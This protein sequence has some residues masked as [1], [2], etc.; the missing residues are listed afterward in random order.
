MRGY[1]VE[2]RTR[3][4]VKGYVIIRKEIKKDLL[5][6]ELDALKTASQKVVHKRVD[7]VGNIIADAVTKANDDKMVKQEPAEERVIPLEKGDEILNNLR[8]VLLLK[9]NTIKYLSY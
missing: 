3:K 1:S 7:F 2:L 5:D 4:Y 8:Q 9:W 6:T